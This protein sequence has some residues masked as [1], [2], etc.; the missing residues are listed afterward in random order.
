[1]KEFLI[2]TIHPISLSQS[3]GSHG[4]VELQPWNWDPASQILSR[5]E[6]PT[7][8]HPLIIAVQQQTS[9]KLLVKLNTR[10]PSKAEFNFA[11]IMEIL[12]IL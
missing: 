7:G 2:K 8:A 12:E 6:D 1:M 4:W 5:P 3:I 11:K 9:N 10:T